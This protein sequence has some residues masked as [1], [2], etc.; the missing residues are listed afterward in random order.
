MQAH[1]T[2]NN[3]NMKIFIAVLFFMCSFLSV[4]AKADTLLIPSTGMNKTYKA[5]V[6]LPDSYGNNTSVF[7]VLYLLHGGF[8]H[9]DDLYLIK[10]HMIIPKDLE[11]IRGNTGKIHCLIMFCFSIMY[12]KLN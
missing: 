12:F 9:F 10:H 1:L 11:D 5:V 4:Y 3:N 2:I 6:V 7:P 8:G